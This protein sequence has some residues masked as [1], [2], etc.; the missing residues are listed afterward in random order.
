[1]IITSNISTII[2]NYWLNISIQFDTHMCLNNEQQG[3]NKSDDDNRIIVAPD[4][5]TIIT[6]YLFNPNIQLKSLNDKQQSD[7]ESDYDNLETNEYA[8]Q[9]SA[10]F[11]SWKSLKNSLKNINLKLD[12]N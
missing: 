6:N 11:S 12:L 7:I 4:I 8:I 10:V 5:S 2:I 1:F 9:I 3:N